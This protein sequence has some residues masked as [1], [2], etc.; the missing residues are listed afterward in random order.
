MG[1]ILTEHYRFVQVLSTFSAAESLH[2]PEYR[3]LAHQTAEL[4][5]PREHTRAQVIYGFSQIYCQA[6]RSIAANNL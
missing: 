2:D 1:E 6:W 4:L 3:G 5:I